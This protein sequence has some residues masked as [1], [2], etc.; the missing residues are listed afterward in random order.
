ML[1]IPFNGVVLCQLRT[2]GQNYISQII[3]KI[4]LHNQVSLK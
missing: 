4:D 3:M 1:Q 2:T